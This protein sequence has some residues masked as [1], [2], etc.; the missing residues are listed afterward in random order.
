MRTYALDVE[1]GNKLESSSPVIYAPKGGSINLHGVKLF[2]SGNYP[3]EYSFKL[4]KPR[5]LC[6]GIHRYGN[7]KSM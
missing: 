4:N 7:N 3:I 2:F 5:S 1:G 6:L